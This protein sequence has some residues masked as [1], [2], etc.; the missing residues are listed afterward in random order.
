MSTLDGSGCTITTKPSG[1]GSTKLRGMCATYAAQTTCPRTCPY[2]PKHDG[3]ACECYAGNGSCKIHTDR[4]NASTN[5]ADMIG[6]IEAA[7]IDSSEC[8]LPLR[9]HVVGDC[10]TI[11]SARRIGNA[12]MRYMERTGETAHTYTHA[13]RVIPRSAWGTIN[14]LASCHTADEVI[15]ATARG[16]ACALVVTHYPDG[17][18]RFPLPGGFT[19]V[20]CPAIQKRIHGCAACKGLC[21]N[22]QR[23]ITRREVV[24]LEV[25]GTGKKRAAEHA[26]NPD[27]DGAK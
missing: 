4:L 26:Y 23:M 2:Y 16:Y 9:I 10:R 5:S 18:R 1:S 8:K 17:A 6:R 24:A 22:D 14:V 21:R 11:E 3:K 25:H 7:L 12:G 15:E 19:T 20:A 13:W 27:T